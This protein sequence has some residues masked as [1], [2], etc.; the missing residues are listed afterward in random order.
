MNLSRL[1]RSASSLAA[2]FPSPC[3]SCGGA[4]P[5]VTNGAL[6]RKCQS[7]IEFCPKNIC[8]V[9]GAPLEFDYEIETGE[10]YKCGECIARPP[11]YEEL[12]FAMVYSGPVRELFHA[13][14]FQSQRRLAAPLAALGQG[15]LAPWLRE[16]PDAV[17]IPT[18][19]AMRKLYTR[20]YNP[21]YLL[22]KI[23]ADMAGLKVAEGALRRIRPTTP[24]FGLN[25]A[26]RVKNVKGAFEVHSPKSIRGRRVIFFDDILTTG[27][28]IRECCKTI[29]KAKP[30][31]L[32]VATLCRVADV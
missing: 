9:C 4:R 21:S 25:S 29:K 11:R 26:Q 8:C 14:K 17:I 15:A 3:V 6:C 28:T 23:L 22:A 19:L 20:G 16:W 13:F 2:L 24:Q 30:K 10:T 32:R 5:G 12:R 27:A 31:A 7:Q 18:P 1:V